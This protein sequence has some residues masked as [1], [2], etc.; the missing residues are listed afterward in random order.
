MKITKEI[1]ILIMFLLEL[2]NSH[3]FGEEVNED[4][5]INKNNKRAQTNSAR[6]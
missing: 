1:S 5:T 6:Q 2:I 3:K 4:G